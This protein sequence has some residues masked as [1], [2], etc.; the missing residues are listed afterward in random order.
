[1]ASKRSI[2][3]TLFASP[4]F[5][6]LSTDTIRLIM[7]GLILDA[8]DEGRGCAHPRLLARKLD[9]QP[10]EIEQ[11]FSELETRSIVLR[12]DVAGRGY[13]VLCHWLTYQILSRPTP[14]IYPA[15]PV[16][17]DGEPFPGFPRGFVGNPGN[18][19]PEGEEEGK[20]REEELEQEGE[21]EGNAQH[22]A[23]APLSLMTAPALV[24]DASDPAAHADSSS[25]EGSQLAHVL[26]LPD[27]THLHAIIHEFAGAAFS[28]ATQAQQA[29]AWID[30]PARNRRQQPMTLAFFHRW[31][32]RERGDY[33]P[34]PLRQQTAASVSSSAL[35]RQRMAVATP[36][37]PYQIYVQQR[38]A[39]L[40]ARYATEGVVS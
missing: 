34:P 5:F 7:I 38:A 33:G 18:A 15:P 29:R 25:W 39:A 26:Q 21:E 23:R 30:D 17:K 1:M 19:L 11:A 20:G 22:P 8:D 6:D 12:Y 24:S 31:L 9:K 14:S 27:T 2:P 36:E 10:Q 3:T 35:A 16:V 28:L 40:Q 37:N 32:K 13:Y 4:D